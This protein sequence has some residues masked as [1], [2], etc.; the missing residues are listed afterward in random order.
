MRDGYVDILSADEATGWATEDVS[1]FVNGTPCAMIAPTI[2]R[3]DLTHGKGFSIALD[4]RLFKP[5]ENEIEVR[6]ASG[7]VVP[8]G[9]QHATYTVSTAYQSGYAAS[10]FPRGLFQI[11]NG[12]Q[13]EQTCEISGRVVYPYG[14]SEAKLF[15][16]GKPVEWTTEQDEG[17][18]LH[19]RLPSGFRTLNFSAKVPVETEVRLAF[20]TEHGSFDPLQDWTLVRTPK[21]QP[22][23]DARRRVAGTG[24]AF[25]FELQGA[26][27]WWKLRNLYE[28]HSSKA[29]EQAKVLDWGVGCGRVGRY[30]LEHCASFT[31]AD[32]DA[33]NIAWCAGNLA[34]D[35]HHTGLTPP[36]P[37]KAASFD[38]VYGI[39][40]LTHLSRKDEAKWLE[41]IARV[42]KKGGIAVLTVNGACSSADMGMLGA[43]LASDGHLDIGRN[44][45][46]DGHVEEGYYR[47][48]I[49][50][51]GH[52][53]RVWSEFFDILE[54]YPRCIGSFQDAVVLRAR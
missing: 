49:H 18:R 19:Y 39:S 12:L 2:D 47:N 48:I 41:E 23:E 33:E 22:P 14:V 40:V 9:S 24:S 52:I 7:D 29:L 3:P 51:E 37:F 21:V 42:T 5:G 10:L 20:G 11:I 54:V 15:A 43:L 34:G 13:G 32:I 16:N 27:N 44:Q 36:L 53:R 6:Y 8:N 38:F 46:L 35:Y 26:A 45:D 25:R 30:M 28:R 4:Q 50:L 17:L 31:G 1:I